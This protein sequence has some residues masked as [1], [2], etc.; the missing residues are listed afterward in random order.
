MPSGPCV[1]MLN[2]VQMR[3]N[4]CIVSLTDHRQATV[5]LKI[6]F[7]II[8]RQFIHKSSPYYKINSQLV[9]SG[10]M[11]WLDARTGHFGFWPGASVN[12]VIK[13]RFRHCLYRCVYGQDEW[14]H[15]YSGFWVFFK[16]HTLQKVMGFTTDWH[17]SVAK[18]DSIA[19]IIL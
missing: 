11:L 15:W 8:A 5:A 9:M 14:H 2:L 6:Q 19:L 16:T 1:M 17:C 12:S 3:L 13:F 18:F 7:W 4:T 10:L